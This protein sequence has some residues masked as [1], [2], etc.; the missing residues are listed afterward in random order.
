MR[1]ISRRGTTVGLALGAAVAVASS[2][3]SPRGATSRPVPL[4]VV[5]SVFP[6]AEVARQIGGARVAV[7]DLTPTGVDPRRLDIRADQLAVVRRADVM[8]DV[9]GGFQPAVERAATSA[10][11]VISL[12]P[13]LG[14]GDPRVWL[15][16]IL[17]E[18][19]TSMIG[20]ALIRVDPLGASEYHRGVREFTARLGALDIDYRSSLADC[21]RQDIVTS[22]EAFRRLT[23]RYGLVEHPIT[24]ASG[25]PALAGLVKAKGLTTVFV[26]PL[27]PA[28]AARSLGHQAHLRIEVLDPIDGLTPAEQ[29][30]GTSYVSLMTDNLATLR[31]ALAC[32]SG[33]PT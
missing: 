30:R 26:E 20:D 7:T 5:A 29:A 25:L 1:S 14:D 33:S 2:C 18:R 10:R 23:N 27:A 31:S 9:G 11:S 19:I 24:G 13:A 8:L 22:Q 17:M 3:G 4:K 16:P 6:L 21:A 28:A 12:L 15:D 32:T